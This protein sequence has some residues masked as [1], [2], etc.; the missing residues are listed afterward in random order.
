M[1]PKAAITITKQA[2]FIAIRI[3]MNIRWPRLMSAGRS[4][5]ARAAT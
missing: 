4:M 3:V 2:E 5:V 1:S